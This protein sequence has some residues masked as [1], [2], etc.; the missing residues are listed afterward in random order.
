MIISKVKGITRNIKDLFV[1]N[2][3]YVFLTKKEKF[4]IFSLL[5]CLLIS[6]IA[7]IVGIASIIPLIEIIKDPMG[8]DNTLLTRYLNI[9]NGL[10][11]FRAVNIAVISSLLIVIFA[12]SARIFSQFFILYVSG[13]LGIFLHNKA[14]YNYLKLP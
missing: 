11:G 1:V 12:Y 4:L 6:S 7:E 5:I 13:E 9:I 3:I 10:T 14:L 2:E 8:I